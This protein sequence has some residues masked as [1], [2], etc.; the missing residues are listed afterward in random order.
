MNLRCE[1]LDLGSEAWDGCSWEGLP[2]PLRLV[3]SLGGEQSSGSCGSES[4]S[5][6]GTEH[7]SW[8]RPLPLKASMRFW[9]LPVVGAGNSLRGEKTRKVSELCLENREIPRRPSVDVWGILSW[10]K[11][12]RMLVWARG[13]RPQVFSPYKGWQTG[14]SLCLRDFFKILGQWRENSY[15]GVS[16]SGVP[17]WG[18]PLECY[19]L[20]LHSDVLLTHRGDTLYLHWTWPSKPSFRSQPF[21]AWT[22]SPPA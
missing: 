18:L 1:N 20:I 8:G 19:L 13:R 5:Q 21:L 10:E 6:K 14:P 22:W 7:W 17:C 12:C 4:W 15:S 11:G 9:I 16:C 2:L 3:P